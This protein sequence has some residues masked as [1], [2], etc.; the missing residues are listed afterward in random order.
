MRVLGSLTLW[1]GLYFLVK[2]GAGFLLYKW[3]GGTLGA[4]YVPILGQTLT[5]F[6]LFSLLSSGGLGRGLVYYSLRENHS[7]DKNEIRSGVKRVSVFLSVTLSCMLL[8]LA[9]EFSYLI[10]GSGE[11]EAA[12]VVVAIV[13]PLLALNN[14]AFSMASIS[15]AKTKFYVLLSTSIILAVIVVLFVGEGYSEVALYYPAIQA[16]VT[17]VLLLVFFGKV[18]IPYIK[19]KFWGRFHE[20][21]LLV[22]YS[23]SIYSSVFLSLGAMIYVRL[24]II[25][26]YSIE[27]AAVWEMVTKLSEGYIQFF[28]LLLA[29]KFFPYLILNKK[30]SLGRVYLSVLCTFLPVAVVVALCLDSFLSFMIPGVES[31]YV[32]MGL[33]IVLGDLFRILLSVLQHQFLASN[34]LKKFVFFELMWVLF[35]CMSTS[36]FGVA[37]LYSYALCY[38]LTFFIVFLILFIYQNWFSGRNC[39]EQKLEST[40]AH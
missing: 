19:A 20:V 21:K 24:I 38:L 8:V 16:V 9:E 39:G 31:T 30:G 15:Q 3:V 25:E 28:G 6:A 32:Y 5:I 27:S 13:M 34:N 4:S 14:L 40:F 1:M 18:I 22:R 36:L 11:F 37:G 17:S 23:L 2:T 12:I 29:Y 26:A 33:M 35:L 7:V 10:Y